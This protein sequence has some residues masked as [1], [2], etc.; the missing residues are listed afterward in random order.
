M[1]ITPLVENCAALITLP[2][3]LVIEQTP[4]IRAVIL[5]LLSQG[6]GHL[7]LDLHNVEKVDASGLSIFITAMNQAQK[8]QGNI[9]LLSPPN[10]VKAL[11]ELTELHFIF[12]IYENKNAAIKFITHQC[13]LVL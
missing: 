3:Q 4:T 12:D 1:Q 11:I 7:I 5:Q 8:Q 10:N 6:V 2:K 9:L 13:Q